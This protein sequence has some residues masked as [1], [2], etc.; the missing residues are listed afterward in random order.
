[1]KYVCFIVLFFF[2]ISR[3]QAQ[4]KTVPD[5]AGTPGAFEKL[6]TPGAKFSPGFFNIYKLNNKYY[7]EIP[8]S[9]L[10]REIL[11]I[12]R[13]VKANAGGGNFADDQIGSESE[14]PVISFSRGTG[15]KIDLRLY[16]Y[17]SVVKDTTGQLLNA[18]N[19]SNRPVISTSFNILAQAKNGHGSIVDLTDLLVNGGVLVKGTASEITEV[20]TY[21]GHIEI[22]AQRSVLNNQLL[23]MNTSMILLPKTPMQVR[24]SDARIG[25]FSTLY[26]E[27]G[28]DS[29]AAKEKSLICRWRLE[30]KPEDLD[31]YKKGILVEPKQPVIYYI[32]PSTPKKWIPYLIQ[33]VNDWEPVFRKAGFKN[34]IMAREAPDKAQ[35]STWTLESCAAA[36]SYKPSATENAFGPNIHDPRSGEILQA[37]I[38]WLHNI[39]K[40]IRNNY[41]IQAGMSDPK[42]RKLIFDD[43]LMGRLI[44][45]IASHEVG[46]TLGLRHNFGASSTVP[47]EKLRNKDWLAA[48]GHTPSIMDYSRYNYVAQPEDH[49]PEEG[50]MPHIGDY[51][52]WAIEWGYRLFPQYSSVEDENDHLNKWV[53]KKLKDG[54]LWWGDGEV[55]NAL[56]P[57]SQTEDL[58]DDGL[59]ADRY[60]ITNLKKVV[61]SLPHWVDTSNGTD[62]DLSDVYHTIISRTIQGV[63]MGQLYN[64]F[65]HILM[66]VGGTYKTPR[67]VEDGTPV[68]VP[69]PKKRQQAAVAFLNKELF[70]T[71]EW[72]VRPEI[73]RRTGDNPLELI[74]AL[75]YGTLNVLFS[76]LWRFGF[77]ETLGEKKRYQMDDLFNDL[78]QG[79]FTELY[80][81]KPVDA[82]RRRLQNVYLNGLTR[83]LTT[84]DPSD[85]HGV[86]RAQL[87]W[88]Q[89]KIALILPDS[90]D[91]ETKSHWLGIQNRIKNLLKSV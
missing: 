85:A 64:Y 71:P 36:I 70:I 12:N 74:Q 27:F 87:V 88:L 52:Q 46:H 13:I 68:Y 69:V 4:D 37:H 83:I 49:I 7:F 5:A 41:M 31:N 8:D 72:V 24:A 54:R 15:L 51:D 11:V 63:P 38:N 32:D 44:R 58:G 30:P 65:Q 55:Q 19:K 50:M 22:K 62:A 1:M 23:E 21:A 34:A 66:L 25:Y 89:D 86:I 67:V 14:T 28:S 2:V 82:Y 78:K 60:G 43:E 47:V 76:R 77:S 9:M 75:Q 59:K 73:L 91:P 81:G 20:R 3:A 80:T 61:D 79:I 18:F 57:R 17:R 48:H 26:T 35:D 29:R 84:P 53:R 40:W 56:D 39:I 16:S 90:K 6:I 33:A 42:G 45:A 10:N